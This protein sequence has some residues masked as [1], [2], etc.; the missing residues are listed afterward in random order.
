MAG[1]III[2]CSDGFWAPLGNET[3]AEAYSG[4]DVMTVTT[5]LMDRAETLA[6]ETA[7]NLS[8][9]AVRWDD[10]YTDI[11][12]TSGGIETL[13][14]PIDAH[15]TMMEGFDRQA[16]GPELTDE[17]IERAIAEIK[18]AIDKYSK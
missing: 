7:D 11:A 8:V 6:G 14:M 9:I 17:E 10:A 1:D 16:R 13:S 15:T 3:L 18:N 2:L 12:T 4:D 5:R